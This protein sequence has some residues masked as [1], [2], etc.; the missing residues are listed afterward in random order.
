MLDGIDDEIFLHVCG[1]DPV[2]VLF[3]V[4]K[5]SFSPR[6]WRFLRISRLTRKTG[7]VDK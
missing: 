2:A 5:A 7:L 6:K 4:D 1:G 3:D